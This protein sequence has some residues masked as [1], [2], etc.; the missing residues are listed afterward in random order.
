MTRPNERATADERGYSLLEFPPFVLVILVF[1]CLFVEMGTY[2]FTTLAADNAS[3]AAA[4]ALAQD[5]S[6]SEDA[7]LAR[8]L[9]ASPAL[10]D[11][12]VSVE[13]TV[14]EPVETPYVHH[15]P[16][17]GGFEDR[18]SYAVGRTV[19][20]KVTVTYRPLSWLGDAMASAI[21]AGGGIEISSAHYTTADAV[22]EQEGG[23][24]RW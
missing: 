15:V 23:A 22:M 18:A 24:S 11:D 3:Y 10:A 4:R 5:V 19:G 14:S 17:G 9:A 21:G 12:A 8:A 20:V 2:A 1:L 16:A 6:M 13:A 7:V